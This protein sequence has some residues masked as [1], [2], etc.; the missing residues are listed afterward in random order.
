MAKHENVLRGLQ[1]LKAFHV[2][3]HAFY[4]KKCSFPNYNLFSEKKKEVLE[5][6]FIYF[7]MFS[8]PKL[9]GI[10]QLHAAF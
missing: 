10:S 9:P 5:V 1:K 3:M 4:K 6:I 7:F 2:L 8:L